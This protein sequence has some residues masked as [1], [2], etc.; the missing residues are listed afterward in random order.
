[1]HGDAVVVSGHMLEPGSGVR[2]RCHK[3][4]RCRR[5]ARHPGADRHDNVSCRCS[6]TGTGVNVIDRGRIEHRVDF[7]LIKVI[8]VAWSWSVISE[9]KEVLQEEGRAISVR[10]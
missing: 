7:E 4:C 2:Q 6:D 1:V 8:T 5:T 10:C 3:L 9:V